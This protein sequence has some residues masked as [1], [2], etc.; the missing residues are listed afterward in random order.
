M[1]TWILV[2]DACEAR[3]FETFDAGR[4][5]HLLNRFAHADSRAMEAELTTDRPGSTHSGAHRGISTMEP[6]TA[7]KEAQAIE[8]AALLAEHLNLA[9]R[10]ALFKAL[11][12]VAPPHFLGLIRKAINPA[13]ARLVTASMAKD[14]INLSDEIIR[15]H[16]AAAVWPGR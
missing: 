9:S 7:Y 15:E 5:L 12:L 13:T 6:H 8:F 3:L 14:L 16:L 2:A 11:V 1:K 10:E 4:T